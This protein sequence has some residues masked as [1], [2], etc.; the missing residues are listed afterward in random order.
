MGRNDVVIIL[1]GIGI[2]CAAS[3]QNPIEY[4]TNA[5]YI[6][7]GTLLTVC[8]I[9]FG[10]GIA[11]VEFIIELAVIGAHSRDTEVCELD[12]AFIGDKDGFGADTSVEDACIMQ[13]AEGCKEGRE[14]SADGTPAQ[15]SG[16]FLEII[17]EI[18]SLDEFI[19]RVGGIIGGKEVDL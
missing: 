13:D 5:V 9:L 16:I 3:G 18:S 10:S 17:E 19:N 7:P 2:G 6:R 14:H 15:F 11:L 4:G 8:E 12:I 1:A